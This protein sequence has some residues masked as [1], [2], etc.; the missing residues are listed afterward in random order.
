MKRG[1]L[2]VI[3]VIILL[4]AVVAGVLIYVQKQG[5]RPGKAIEPPIVYSQPEEQPVE[6]IIYTAPEPTPPPVEKP[7]QVPPK[8]ESQSCIARYSAYSCDA[9]KKLALKQ[10]PR[11]YKCSTI[12]I[13]WSAQ[14]C[15]LEL[16]C[17]P[18]ASGIVKKETQ[19][20][21]ALPQPYGEGYYRRPPSS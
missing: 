20:P 7:V 9:A 21:Q 17:K 4:I 10:C 5:A 12:S 18:A 6:K 16:E 2:G 11:D 1:Q 14:G 19:T 8:P 3:L 15:A 13:G